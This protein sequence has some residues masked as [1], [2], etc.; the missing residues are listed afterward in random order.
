MTL[1]I[2]PITTLL[3]FVIGH[4][5]SSMTYAAIEYQPPEI[6]AATPADDAATLSKARLRRARRFRRFAAG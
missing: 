1:Q 4:V 3:H 2:L 6:Q 5:I